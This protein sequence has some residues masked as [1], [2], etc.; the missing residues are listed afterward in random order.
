MT[1]D[2]DIDLAAVDAHKEIEEIRGHLKSLDDSASIDFDID[3]DLKDKIQQLTKDL[4]EINVDVDYKELEEAAMLKSM[5]EGDID[6]DLNVDREKWMEDLEGDLDPTGDTAGGGGGSSGSDG[7][8][9][10]L[11][12]VLDQQKRL[13]GDNRRPHPGDGP[14]S[15]FA[16]DSY[17]KDFLD[18]E[19]SSMRKP[20]YRKGDESRFMDSTQGQRFGP[21][22]DKY[23]RRSQFTQDMRNPLAVDIDT[24]RLERTKTSIDRR[25]LLKGFDR[26]DLDGFGLSGSGGGVLPDLD[27]D[28]TAGLESIN[29]KIKKLIPNMNTFYTAFAAVLP[30][31]VSMGTQALGVAAAMGSVAVAGASIIGLGLVGHGEDM[32]SSMANAKKQ[33]KELGTELFS[34]FQPTMQT[35][36]PIQ[37]ELFDRLPG[38]LQGVATSMEGLTAFSDTLFAS[39]QGLTD[40]IGDFFDLIVGNEGVISQLTMRFGEIIGTNILEFFQFLITEA[41]EN[42]EMLISLGGALKSMLGVIYKVSTAIARIV[43]VFSPLAGVLNWVAGL[44]NN[45][46]IIGLLTFAV[47]L[48]GIIYT[49]VA[50][51]GA[52]AWLGTL[53]AGGFIST[54]VSS[55]VSLHAWMTAAIE[56][57]FA[58]Y[59]LAGGIASVVS[60]LTLGI[61]ALLAF[62][63]A[64]K[65]VDG[66]QAEAKMDHNMPS[67]GPGGYGPG[68]GGRSAQSVTN[69]GD[70]YNVEVY[71]NMDNATQEGMRD[72]FKTEQ[73]ISEARQPPDSGGS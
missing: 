25:H 54:V 19:R 58:A 59:G 61:G 10:P 12:R 42:Q 34:V 2:I 38:M 68:A 49:V 37:A 47:T 51:S 31:L 72:M 63:V 18:Q 27:D 1:V 17:F 69:Q 64:M 36:A 46:L 33:V 70:T 48:G 30:L 60:M 22:V 24:E 16:G 65:A 50:L 55:I 23:R 14:P 32:A 44:L 41:Y 43:A 21:D 5:L 20:W 56:A 71:G 26:P 39:F 29:Q 73:G 9:T 11:Q 13:L 57:K 52:I 8:R 15:V 53:W 28:D 40:W 6:A 4:K 66:L 67:G 35:F 3:G 45:K 62:G 7:K